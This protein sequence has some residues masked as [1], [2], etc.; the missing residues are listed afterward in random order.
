MLVQHRLALGQSARI[1]R[2]LW[3]MPAVSH[4]L[5][6]NGS[7][8]HNHTDLAGT[9]RER[10]DCSWCQ[11]STARAEGFRLEEI[12]VLTRLGRPNKPSRV[13]GKFP[14]ASRAA[15]GLI[16]LCWCVPL[17]AYDRPSIRH[18]S[19][20]RLQNIFVISLDIGMCSSYNIFAPM[21]TFSLCV[22]SLRQAP[23]SLLTDRGFVVSLDHLLAQTSTVRPF[24]TVPVPWH[25]S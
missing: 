1:Q 10:G 18:S 2:Y 17:L 6:S 5:W 23:I 3:S 20:K 16:P 14:G 15:H 19:S 21:V 13:V 4:C 24:H 22:V 12:R 9:R 11:R 25:P 7:H 8:A